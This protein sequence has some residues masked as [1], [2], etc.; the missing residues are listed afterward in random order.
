M[1]MYLEFTNDTWV[2]TD[3]GLVKL[4]DLLSRD[5]DHVLWAVSWDT[6]NITFH[7][8]HSSIREFVKL[9]VGASTVGPARLVSVSQYIFDAV[10]TKGFL[11]T[12]L[13]S[14]EEAADYDGTTRPEKVCLD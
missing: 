13:K 8:N 6:G 7:P 14:F 5:V 11:C 10:A 2:M 4:R 9:Q 3:N 1:E 12:P